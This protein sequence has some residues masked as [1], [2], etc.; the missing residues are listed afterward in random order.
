MVRLSLPRGDGDGCGGV[1]DD[2]LPPD[3]LL[4]PL[5]LGSLP[6]TLSLVTVLSRGLEMG[7]TGAVE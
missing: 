2:L 5:Q 6:P 1:R 4:L 3:L 7:M